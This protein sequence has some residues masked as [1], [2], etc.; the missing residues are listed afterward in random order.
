MAT[1]LNQDRA[2]LND[3]IG[4]ALLETSINWIASNLNPEDVFSE[5]D[6]ANWAEE[7]GY[8]QGA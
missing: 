6:L 1:T 2:F 4:D 5:S 7:N 3:V 8:V